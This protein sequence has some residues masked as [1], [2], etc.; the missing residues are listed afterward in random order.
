MTGSGEPPVRIV[1][2]VRPFDPIP[3][4]EVAVAA[5]EGLT[6]PYALIGGIA[7][8]AWGM[9]RA[10][11]D[12]GFAVPVGTAEAAA[13]TIKVEGVQ[14]RPLRIGGVGLRG[15]VLDL[16]IDLIDRRFQYG[17]LVR[18]AIEEAV[19]SRRRARIGRHEVPLVS[20]EFLLAMKMVSGEDKDDIDAQR[21]LQREE[22]DYRLATEII[23]KH[24]GHASRNR[25]D[26]WARSVGRP[27]L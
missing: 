23:E 15:S 11:K 10:T 18:E 27:E 24:L 9:S 21:I 12:I 13:S 25:L 26:K 16:H 17:A 4:V 14:T 3:S 5:L 1:G 19:G 22:L 8:D 7:L 20:L 6:A 2:E